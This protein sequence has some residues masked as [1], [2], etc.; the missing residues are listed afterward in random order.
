MIH[1]S[2]FVFDMYYFIRILRWLA[3][4]VAESNLP[5]NFHQTNKPVSPEYYKTLGERL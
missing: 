3:N 4:L 5:V 1:K 2:V